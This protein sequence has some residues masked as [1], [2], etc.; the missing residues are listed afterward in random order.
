[1]L[2]EDTLLKL[3]AEFSLPLAAMTTDK[4]LDDDTSDQ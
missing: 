4:N 1:V 2:T 3:F